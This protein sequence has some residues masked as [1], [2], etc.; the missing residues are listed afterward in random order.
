MSSW[1]GLSLVNEFANELG[2]TSTAFK[3]K[4][5][6]YINDGLRDISSS[7]RWAQLREKG[8]KVLSAGANSHSL[9]LGKPSAPSAVVAAG[10]ALTADVEFKFLVTFYESQAEIESI[11]GEPSS[12]VT[13]TGGNLSVDLSSI[14]VSADPLV[15]ARK[16]YVSRAGGSYTY[17]STINDNTTTDLSV[18]AENTN[19]VTAPTEHHISQLE[20]DLFIEGS[21]ILEG[22][23]LH[24]FTYKTASFAASGTPQAWTPVN[25][26]EVMV[27]P[28]PS[29]DT[30]VSFFYYKRPAQV[31]GI[32]SSVPQM[33]SWI[34]DDLRRYVMWRGFDYRDRAGKESK[35]ITY[36]EN[37]KLT[38]SRKGSPVKKSGKV[39]MMT[40]DSDGRLG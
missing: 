30:T 29:V 35:E 4:V 6:G 37:L 21:R 28:K 26:E 22:L 7:F 24:D 15:T 11:A 33:P 8:Q 27:Y 18:V 23:S 36:R 3:L 38:F 16:L 1:N 32:A 34:Y 10:G 2:D 12:G 19:P 9:T 5:L 17:H 39:R 20:G 13:P 40:A 25:E 31:F 14:P